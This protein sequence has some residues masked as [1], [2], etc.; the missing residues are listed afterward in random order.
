MSLLFLNIQIPESFLWYG[1]PEEEGSYMTI[2]L[3]D[4]N[5]NQTSFWAA[6]KWIHLCLSFE[7]RRGHLML[8]KVQ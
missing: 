1:H 6:N 2:L 5:T 4:P 8:V 7:K 3:K